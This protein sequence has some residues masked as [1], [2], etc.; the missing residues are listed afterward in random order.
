MISS[1][2]LLAGYSS[3]RFACI[4]SERRDLKHR[5]TTYQRD[6]STSLSLNSTSSGPSTYSYSYVLSFPVML[7]KSV[8]LQVGLGKRNHLD[9][10]YQIPFA[11]L[12]TYVLPL[13]FFLPA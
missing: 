2:G 4:V 13:P 11:G 1:I 5:V 9:H 6:N 3:K 7:P 8:P 10:Q 12:L